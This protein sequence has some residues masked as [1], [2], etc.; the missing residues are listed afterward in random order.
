MSDAQTN[1][2]IVRANVLDDGS[3]AI[4]VSR[5]P[6][7]GFEPDFRRGQINVSGAMKTHKDTDNFLCQAKTG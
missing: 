2:V 6:A 5:M 3:Q 1:A 7:T 4:V